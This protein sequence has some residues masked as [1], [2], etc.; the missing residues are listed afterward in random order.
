[1]A[2]RYSVAVLFHG[3]A[4]MA[5]A[6]AAC[7]WSRVVPSRAWAAMPCMTTLVYVASVGRVRSLAQITRLTGRKQ[8][9]YAHIHRAKPAKPSEKSVPGVAKSYETDRYR[10]ATASTG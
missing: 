7:S 5:C 6:A 2:R 9:L 8:R 4:C 1:M 3:H 10:L